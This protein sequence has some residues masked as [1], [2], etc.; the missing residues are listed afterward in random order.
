MSTAGWFTEFFTPPARVTAR[1]R[2]AGI[3]AIGWA[4]VAFVGL[5]LLPWIAGVAYL[6]ARLTGRA[7]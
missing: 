3:A 7:A 2:I 6:I 1:D 5:M 4:V